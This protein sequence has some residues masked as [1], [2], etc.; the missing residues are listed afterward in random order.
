MRRLRFPNEHTALFLLS[1]FIGFTLWSYITAARNP[2]VEQSTSKL[3]AVLPAIAGE[4]AYGYTLLGIR[5]TPQTVP[6]A[7]DPKTL[8]QIQSVSTETVNISGATR[9][10]VQEVSVV[11][12]SGVRTGGRVRVA[13]QIVPA[14]AVT[15]VRGIRVEPPE[16]GSGLVVDIEPALVQVQVQGPVTLVNRLRASDFSARLDSPAVE[17]GRRRAQV[18]VQAPPQV[19]VLSIVP[20]AVVVIVRK[21]G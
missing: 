3:A 12:P 16:V 17:E 7:G 1:L 9:D 20:A 21:G 18:R 14:I 19:E 13:V 11:A 4:P 6:V 8:A 15:T 5:V 2:R 10:F